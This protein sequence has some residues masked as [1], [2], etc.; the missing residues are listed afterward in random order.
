LGRLLEDEYSGTLELSSPTRALTGDMRAR[1]LPSHIER[2]PPVVSLHPASLSSPR[3]P[4]LSLALS[5]SLPLCFSPPISPLCSPIYLIMT[6]HAS[7]GTTGV[8]VASD[9]LY[10][11]HFYSRTDADRIY[12]ALQSELVYVPRAYGE[13]CK[14]ARRRSGGSSSST[15][16][17]P[18]RCHRVRWRSWVKTG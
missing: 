5:L 6:V 4:S 11:E 17:R 9:S 3:S 16:P 15:Y 8:R 13:G 14:Q 18:T 12:A 10:Y 7:S 2:S 1:I